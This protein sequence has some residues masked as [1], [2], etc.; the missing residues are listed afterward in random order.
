MDLPV[1]EVVG[2]TVTLSV[3]FM[4]YL[5]WKRAKRSGTFIEDR[6]AAYKAVWQALEEAH[7]LVRTGECDEQTFH[8]RI[9]NVNTLLIQH[10]L[11]I[12]K[13]DKRRAAD[14]MHALGELGRLLAAMDPAD[15]PRREIGLTE[16]G[17]ATSPE[18]M[19]TYKAY[20]SA[21][22]STIDGFRRAIGAGQV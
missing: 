2:A 10:G 22:Q 17:V 6:Q 5:Q 20:E 21:R 13:A 9:K 1:K 18:F 12:A 8:A 7:L 19:H 3:A 14:Y 4:G 15:S 11:H 16:E